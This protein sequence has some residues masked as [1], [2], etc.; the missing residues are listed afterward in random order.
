MGSGF[1]FPHLIIRVLLL[2]PISHLGKCMNDVS[3]CC[4]SYCF[5]MHLIFCNV[6]PETYSMNLECVISLDIFLLFLFA[7]LESEPNDSS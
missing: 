5:S 7:K 3:E 6:S 1:N 2:T 4:C